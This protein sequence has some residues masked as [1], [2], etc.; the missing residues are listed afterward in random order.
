MVFEPNEN[1]VRWGCRRGML[2]LDLFLL[3]FFDAHYTSLN[4]EEQAVF[5]AL[6][7]AEDPQLQQW[8]M[9]QLTHEDR[10]SRDMI[11]RIC[12]YAKA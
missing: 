10:H 3:P 5:Q 12:A 9:Q 2:E 8:F 11:E 1:R 7:T 4:Q 6:L